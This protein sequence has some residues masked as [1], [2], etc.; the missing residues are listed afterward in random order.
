MFRRQGYWPSRSILRQWPEPGRLEVGP[1]YI[2]LGA[3]IGDQGAALQLM[4]LGE[5]LKLW[6]VL[7]PTK[8]GATPEQAR[9]A[10]QH[11]FLM[12][13]GFNAGT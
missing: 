7:T 10:A 13:G 5:A 6:V 8:L 1:S 4:A 2:E 9:I 12:I 11:G 3:I